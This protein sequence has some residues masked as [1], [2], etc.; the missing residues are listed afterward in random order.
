MATTFSVSELA[1]KVRAWLGGQTTSPNVAPESYKLETTA[2]TSEKYAVVLAAVYTVGPRSLDDKSSA[3][4]EEP[5]LRR[6]K[7]LAPPDHVSP[8]GGFPRR[9]RDLLQRHVS[10]LAAGMSTEEMFVMGRTSFVKEALRRVN[11]DLLGNSAGG[12]GG[13]LVYRARVER[14]AVEVP[15]DTVSLAVVAEEGAAPKTAFTLHH[16]VKLMVNL[17]LVPGEASVSV[18][19]AEGEPVSVVKLPAGGVGAELH[20]E[21]H[22]KTTLRLQLKGPISVS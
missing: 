5:L 1:T 8:A 11:L 6:A 2:A 18:D 7:L 15:C 21:L 19:R 20:T 9:V 12:G 16:V 22:G 4:S 14:L 3:G 13:L 17:S 10:A